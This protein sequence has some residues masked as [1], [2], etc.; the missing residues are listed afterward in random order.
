MRGN[1]WVATYF[2]TTCPG[3]CLRLNPNIQFMN[4]LPELKDVTWVSITCDPDTDT[5]EALRSVRRPLA[6]RPRA[7]ALLPGRPRL[8]PARRQ[9]HECRL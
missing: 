3:N 9:G 4:N 1:V 5:L 7:L 6:G 8:H 2:F